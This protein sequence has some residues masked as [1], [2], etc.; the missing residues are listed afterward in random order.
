[1]KFILSL[2]LFLTACAAQHAKLSLPAVPATQYDCVAITAHA[3]GATPDCQA[4]VAAF[5]RGR[6]RVVKLYPAASQVKLEDIFF[7]RPHLVYVDDKPYPLFDSLNGL[8]PGEQLVRGLTSADGPVLIQYAYEDIVEHE[9][10]H[11]LMRLVAGAVLRSPEA[12]EASTPD[13]QAEYL[14]M[15]SCH[16]T[17]DDQYGEPGNIAS[18]ILPYTLQAVR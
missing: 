9:A 18:C 7:Y 4:I 5:E 10:V 17:S 2:C 14:W 3:E 6:A 12:I 13:Q 1:M 15:E 16:G 11:A 8:G